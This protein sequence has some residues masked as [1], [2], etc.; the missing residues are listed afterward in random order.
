MGQ[1]GWIIFV[2]SERYL[3]FIKSIHLI[4]AAGM[5]QRVYTFVEKQPRPCIAASRLPFVDRR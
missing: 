5:T 2:V 3:S 4:I 1:Y